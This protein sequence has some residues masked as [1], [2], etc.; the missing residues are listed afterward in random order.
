MLDTFSFGVSS[1]SSQQKS[2]YMPINSAVGLL[3]SNKFEETLNKKVSSSPTC[4]RY[5][6][7]TLGPKLKFFVPVGGK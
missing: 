7:L 1:N 4:Q 6:N 5:L 3:W 2:S